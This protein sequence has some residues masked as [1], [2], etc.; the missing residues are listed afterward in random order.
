MIHNLLNI[1]QGFL[2][3]I[4]NFGQL[5]ITEQLK[6]MAISFGV[7]FLPLS[8]MLSMINKKK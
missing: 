7:L 3:E 2:Q 4:Q 5:S 8:V 1:I 6:V